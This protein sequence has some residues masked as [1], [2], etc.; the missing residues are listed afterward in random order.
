MLSVLQ[1]HLE[2]LHTHAGARSVHSTGTIEASDAGEEHVFDV[3]RVL[4]FRCRDGLI[5]GGINRR[6]PHRRLEL[7]LRVGFPEVI[8][9]R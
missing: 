2:V 4:D 1:V 6:V 7:V 3:G 5:R 9:Y 8:Q